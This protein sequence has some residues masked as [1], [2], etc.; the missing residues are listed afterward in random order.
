MASATLAELI[1]R[2][3]NDGSELIDK[4]IELAK[5][6][7]KDDLGE[8][9][10]T[11]K[12]GAIA[13]GLALAA[14][15]LATIW[16]FTAVIWFFNWLGE[17]LLGLAGLGWLGASLGWLIGLIIVAVLGWISYRTIMRTVRRGK[18]IRPLARTRTTLKE[19]LE[20]VRQLRTPSA[21]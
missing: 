6:E 16:L 20:W 5:Q 18:S 7:V 19:D 11:A 21:K 14:G 3:V 17:K 13:A 2:L 12:T 4:Q 10:A 9:V 15:L 1:G 8:V